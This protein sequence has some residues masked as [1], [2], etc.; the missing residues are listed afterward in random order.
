MTGHVNQT[1][2]ELE[3]SVLNAIPLKK[4][5]ERYS[6]E[7]VLKHYSPQARLRGVTLEE[8]LR[9]LG[10]EELN[11]LRKILDQPTIPE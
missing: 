4:V 7:E 8:R 5:L 6:S 2:E 11:H 3:A 10:E 1:F 9:G